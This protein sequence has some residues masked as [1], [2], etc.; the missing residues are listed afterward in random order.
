M[1]PGRMSEQL[2]NDNVDRLNEDLRV[3]IEQLRGNCEYCKHFNSGLFFG[4]MACELT[5]NHDGWEWD[6]EKRTPKPLLN[7]PSSMF[8]SNPNKEVDP[9]TV[10]L[11]ENRFIGSFRSWCRMKDKP[12]TPLN[13]FLFLSKLGLIDVER[14]TENGGNYNENWLV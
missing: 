2:T 1:S 14:L 10:E 9:H 5:A 8:Y 11:F 7:G 6:R 3:A 4:C 12:E 13:M